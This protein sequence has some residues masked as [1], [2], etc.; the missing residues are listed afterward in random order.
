[1][2]IVEWLSEANSPKIRLERSGTGPAELLLIHGIGS[3]GSDF[4]RLISSLDEGRSVVAPDLRG[5]GQSEARLPV[6][7]EEFAADLLPLLD[8]EGPMAVAGFSFG[9][10]VAMEIWRMRPEAVS[11]LVIVDPPLIYGPLFEWAS[12]GGTGRHRFRA[13]LR[14]IARLPGL[15]RIRR[16]RPAARPLSER[17]VGRITA[18]YHAVDLEEAVSLMSEN[19]LTSD[20]DEADL[21]ANARSLMMADRATLLATLDLTGRPEDQ[22]GPTESPVE[23]VVLFGDRSPMTNLRSAGTFAGGVGGRVVPY[24]GGHVAH[25]EAPVAVAAEIEKLFPI[26]N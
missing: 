9:A 20:L 18:I 21:L 25:L 2:T 24:Q 16:R 1:M 22:E 15:D 5:H 14:R 8:R 7:I 17:A 12:A 13:I 10:W 4:T 19:P 26:R 6:T 3:R 23:P 11:A